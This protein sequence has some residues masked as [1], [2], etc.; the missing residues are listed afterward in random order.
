MAKGRQ[1]GYDG[2]TPPGGSRENA[3]GGNAGAGGAGGGSGGNGGGG[4]FRGRK[5]TT[6]SFCGKTSRDV[7]PMVEGPNDVYICSNC[8]DLCQNIFKQE[9]RRG[10]SASALFTEVP[11]PR[12]IKQFLD[13]YVIGQDHAKK[14]LSV[15]VHS[16]Y[17]RLLHSEK[18]EQDVELDKSNV[19]LIG[20]TGSGKTL[21]ARTLA[22]ILNVPFAIGDATTLTEAG[23]VGEDVEN[24]LLKLLQAA[25]YDLEAA[26][27][28]IIYIDEI[29]K[30]GKTHNN[31]SITRDVSGEG[32]QQSLLKMLE[33]TISNVPPQGGRKHPEQQYIQMDTTHILFICGGTFVGI[34]DIIRRRVGK[35]RI[36]FSESRDPTHA[37]QERAEVLAQVTPDDILEFG[38][39]PE[40]IGRLP[41]IT[42]LMPLGHEALMKVLT[43]PRNAL[44]RQY[45]HMFSLEGAKLTYT[46]RALR[47]IAEKALKRA[48]GARAL[49][50]VMEEVMLDMMYDLPDQANEGA[51]YIVDEADV[52]R[53]RRLS[54]LRV[55][56]KESAA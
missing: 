45:Q 19:L 6:C 10:S 16:H 52:L 23:Y 47:A 5:V 24:L 14:A 36:G 51:E 20:P 41:V 13:Q 28:G 17:K 49:R 26:Q 18:E 11:A 4:G 32:V 53:P 44:I 30:I 22:R 38:M 8:T 21:L 12:E 39:I 46:P 35:K 48:T 9:R 1:D 33:G 43:E 15:A 27:R 56:A 7:G 54:E 29:D 55:K 42:P 50:A 2:S 34:E 40:L 3:G 37:E 25:D 31:V